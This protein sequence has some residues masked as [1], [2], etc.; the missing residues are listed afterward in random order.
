MVAGKNETRCFSQVGVCFIE[1]IDSK[2]IAIWQP[3]MIGA[4]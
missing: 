3:P 4:A 2:V 1:V